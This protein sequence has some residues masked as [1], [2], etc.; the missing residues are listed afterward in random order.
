[1]QAGRLVLTQQHQKKLDN[2]EGWKLLKDEERDET[3]A[4][5]Q[6]VVGDDDHHH[7]KKKCHG[8]QHNEEI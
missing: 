5:A 4:A 8:F 3:T 2:V 6:Q 1:M 7:N